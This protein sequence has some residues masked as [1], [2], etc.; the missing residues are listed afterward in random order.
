VELRYSQPPKET[1]EVSTTSGSIE[2]VVP[3]KSSFELHAESRSGEIESDFE[4]VSKQVKEER[5]TATVD[6]KVGTRGPQIRLKTTYGTIRL[7]K[8]K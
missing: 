8:G 3:A 1:I 2:L 4:E 6:A 7:R 5:G